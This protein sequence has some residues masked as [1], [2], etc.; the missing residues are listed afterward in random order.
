MEKWECEK[1]KD[2]LEDTIKNP[3]QYHLDPYDYG[4][5]H[6]RDI[7]DAEMYYEE[8]RFYCACRKRRIQ[9]EEDVQEEEPDA[10]RLNVSAAEAEDGSGSERET[11]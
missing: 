9:V 4:N 5:H 6:L 3:V 1:A 8:R 7:L 2:Y 11:V 10:K